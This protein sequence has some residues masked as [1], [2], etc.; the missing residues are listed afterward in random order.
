MART[1]AYKLGRVVKQAAAE[2]D[3]EARR[4]HWS[5][6]P[7][8]SEGT[9]FP[10]SNN[11]PGKLLGY[12]AFGNNVYLSPLQGIVAV[13]HETG[14]VY[15]YPQFIDALKKQPGYFGQP[16]EKAF[17]SSA[18]AKLIKTLTRGST[19]SKPKSPADKKKKD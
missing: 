11:A 16:T 9:V 4:L 1:F 2:T 14:D 18:A 5:S 7:R 15:S 19:P 3:E 8:L 12:D 10:E 6:G 13:D 17:D